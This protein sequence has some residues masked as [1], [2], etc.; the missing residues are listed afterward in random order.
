[1]RARANKIRKK[2][3]QKKRLRL[4]KEKTTEV[5]NFPGVDDPEAFAETDGALLNQTVL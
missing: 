4:E 3:L 1:V 5:H 2:A